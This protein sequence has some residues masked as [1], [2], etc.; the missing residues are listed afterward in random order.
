MTCIAPRSPG[1]PCPN[2]RQ[3]GSL[4]CRRHERAPAARRGGWLSAYQRRRKMGGMDQP[5]DASAIFPRL[6]V[7]G[8][9]PL[10]RDLPEFDVLV[11]CAREI[12]PPALAFHGRVVRCPIPDDVLDTPQMRMALAAAGATA[13]ALTSGQRVLVTCAQGI[14]RSAF[15]A[16]LALAQITRMSALELVTLMRTK[17]HQDALFNKYFQEVLKRLVGSGR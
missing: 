1:V 16:S 7:G 4:L 17:R 10:D 14:N 3:P 9:P 11:L 6:W 2:Q 8:R 5:I 15:V 13:R 12:Q